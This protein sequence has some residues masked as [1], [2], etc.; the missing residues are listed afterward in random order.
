MQAPQLSAHL[1]VREMLSMPRTAPLG[2]AN[3]RTRV[4]VCASSRPT[5]AT[6]PPTAEVSTALLRT[7]SAGTEVSV[8]FTVALE[9]GVT[10]TYTAD[11]VWPDESVRE[12]CAR[13][14]ERTDL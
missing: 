13:G 4:V 10:C 3:V 14:C 9:S 11:A 2:D 7:M 1:T 12:G 8:M 5:A 6:V